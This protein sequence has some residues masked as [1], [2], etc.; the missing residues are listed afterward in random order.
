MENK[1]TLQK[2]Y[3]DAIGGGL[4]GMVAMSVQ[5]STLM[6][7]RTT[8]NYQYKYGTNM[9]TALN[10]LYKQ[11]GIPRF[12]R[13]YTAA[14][15]QAPLSRFGDT[16]SNAGMLTLL[17]SYD[18][19]KTLPISVKTLCASTTA[20][21]FRVLL[22]PIDTIKTIMQVEG[23]NGISI[24][25][26]KIHINGYSVM[27]NGTLASSLAT[28]IG[29]YPWFTTYNYLNSILV[30]YNEK[31]K[32]LLRSA[33]IGFSSSMISDT[34]SNS[35]R[36][37]KTTKQTSQ[38]HITYKNAIQQVIEKDGIKGLFGRGLVTKIMT[39][40]VQGIMFSVIWKLGQDYYKLR[41][42]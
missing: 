40:G 6:W 21:S 8:V 29:H 22:M 5:V 11:G 19:T 32:S 38:N 27:F 4:P 28:F 7:L 33:F 18:S 39:N 1:S 15:L 14:I 13:G 24:L 9:I 12:Y 42:N 30:D 35:I 16:A 23:K 26:N 31:Y 2:V 20:A 41:Y 10:T 17:N 36:V 37:I 25:K 34:V 3:K